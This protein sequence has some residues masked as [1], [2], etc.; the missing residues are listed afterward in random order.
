MSKENRV[1]EYVMEGEGE[2][3]INVFGWKMGYCRYQVCED[4]EKCFSIKVLKKK[5]IETLKAMRM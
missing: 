2:S 1:G 4:I 5:I 3:N